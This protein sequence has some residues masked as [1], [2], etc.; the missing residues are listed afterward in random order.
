M[1]VSIDDI[2]SATGIEVPED[3]GGQVEFLIRSA[4]AAVEGYLGYAV[5]EPVPDAVMVVV[6]TRM[7]A[8][9]LGRRS[10]DAPTGITGDMFVAGSFTRQRQFASG[11]NDGGVW[12]S[13]QDKI[14]LKPYKTPQAVRS[15]PY[16]GF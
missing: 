8:R 4:V 13:A 10:R 2:Q 16:R 14:M 11:S 5:E 7:V 3:E 1:L 9:L 6:V 15:V 12:L